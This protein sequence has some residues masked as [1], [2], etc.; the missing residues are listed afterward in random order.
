M[1]GEGGAGAGSWVYYPYGFACCSQ[2]YSGEPGNGYRSTGHQGYVFNGHGGDT[3]FL[4]VVAGGGKGGAGYI[5]TFHPSYPGSYIW[6]E[7]SSYFSSPSPPGDSSGGT[8]TI[9]TGVTPLTI[10][11]GN[12]GQSGTATNS[13][14]VGGVGP[15]GNGSNGALN[16]RP[17]CGNQG[18]STVCCPGGGCGYYGGQVGTNFVVQWILYNVRSY[19]DGGGGGAGAYV[20][21]QIPY[22]YLQANG[23][24]GTQQPL[25][26]N[27]GAS[28]LD[29]G[30]AEIIYGFG[31]VYIKTSQGWQLVNNVYVK[32]SDVNIGWKTSAPHA[33]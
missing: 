24:P 23:Y 20:E 4:G 6:A 12:S 11:Q 8:Y 5:Y 27:E 19:A 33:L 1:K 3:S 16:W 29:N 13:V 32:H 21:V 31:S 2:F 22:T 26:L 15:G 28:G 17:T 9:P 10:Q 7:Y 18:Y 30:S 25:T 14:K